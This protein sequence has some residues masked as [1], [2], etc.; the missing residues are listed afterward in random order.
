MGEGGRKGAGGGPARAQRA[1]T[2]QR[3]T[4]GEL[5]LL[6]SLSIIILQ[7]ATCVVVSGHVSPA[8]QLS[9]PSP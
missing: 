5:N 9:P 3:D 6:L 4:A 2:A 7:S 8:Q 1:E